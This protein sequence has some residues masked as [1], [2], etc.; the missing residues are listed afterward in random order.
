VFDVPHTYI[1]K[2]LTFFILQLKLNI[3]FEDSPSP[4]DILMSP[5]TLRYSIDRT[6]I[7]L[8]NEV[9]EVGALTNE[10]LNA[11]FLERYNDMMIF[12]TSTN[13]SQFSLTSPFEINYISTATFPF[14]TQSIPTF[15]ELEQ[16]LLGAFTAPQDEAY[17]DLLQ[18]LPD[19]NIFSTTANV[20]GDIT[21]VRVSPATR[22]ARSKVT[23]GAAT[24]AIAFIL[25]IGG[26]L[27]LQQRRSTKPSQ[28]RLKNNGSYGFRSD[29]VNKISGYATVAGDTFPETSTVW[30]GTTKPKSGIAEENPYLDDD[31]LSL[32][33]NSVWTT[34]NNDSRHTMEYGVH[35]D[36]DEINAIAAIVEASEKDSLLMRENAADAN[37][38]KNDLAS[39]RELD[40]D[41]LRCDN[42]TSSSHSDDTECG[43]LCSRSKGLDDCNDDDYSVDANV[44]LR[45]VDLIK[46]FS[47]KI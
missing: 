27:C 34:K 22:T 43:N 13:G 25:M 30:S 15:D 33:D 1:Y 21:A 28:K 12:S 10:Y 16:T 37:V 24:G 2:N 47:S 9:D 36:D 8:N 7:P 32:E 14:G 11:L 38:R 5:Y 41:P 4:I 44:P 31:G 45:V 40:S 3:L 17:L 26:V 20:T 29:G 19:T 18:A 6:R 46:R 23:V 42:Q 39:C 35:M